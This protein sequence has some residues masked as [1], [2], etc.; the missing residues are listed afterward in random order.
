MK[1]LIILSIGLAVSCSAFCQS[2]F[3]STLQ[4][5]VSLP[6]KS[7]GVNS[8]HMGEGIY[9]GNHLDY[10]AGDGRVKFGLGIYFGYLNTVNTNVEYKKIGQS[11]ADK[12]NL[13]QSQINFNASDFK[14]THLLL[15]PVASFQSHNWNINLWAKG[16]YGLN[17]PGRYA[18]VFKE[19]NLVN[20]IYVNDAGEN[21]NGLAY[22]FGGGIQYFISGNVG[23][24]LG[25]N[26]FGTQTSQ[27]NYN[28]NREKG[29]SPL[30][31]TAKNNFIQASLGINLKFGKETNG[32]QYTNR[33]KSRSN[34]QNN[35]SIAD[36]NDE[37]IIV[38][39]IT[40]SRSNIQNNRSIPEDNNDDDIIVQRIT[41][42][43]S[44]IQN[45]RSIAEDNDED[46]NESTDDDSLVFV[47]E[48]I[49]I[50]TER[51]TPKRDFGDRSVNQ[52]QSVNNYLTG[53]V[54][55][56][57]NGVAI[58]QCGINSMESDPIPGVDV[59]FKRIG[60]A[61]ND[62]MSLST[63]ANKDGSFSFNNIKPGNYI[64]E[65]GD[66]KINIAVKGDNENEYK[67]LDI[68]NSSC[69]NVKENY[70]I[71]IN[72]TLYVEVLPED[73]A[74]TGMATGKKHG[75]NIKWSER[76][77]SSHDAGS[78][79]PTGKRMHKPFKVEGTQFDVDLDNVISNN[80]KNYAEIITAREASTG[81]ATGRLL[82]TVNKKEI[83][84]DEPGV[85]KNIVTPRDPA[86]GL[87]TGKR[88]HKPFKVEDTEFDVDLDNVISSDGKN[89]AEIITAGEAS[90]GMATGR[91]L[92]TVNKKE[93]P[94][95]PASG[96]PTGKRMHKPYKVADTEFDINNEN[97]IKYDG[98]SYA[99]VITAREAGSG[100]ATGRILIT[101]DVDGDG[102]ED[103]AIVS[104]RDP[105]S[106][107]STGKRMHKPFVITKELDADENEIISPRENGSGL[108]TGK[109]MHKPFI[110]T[111]ELD[112]DENEIIS[113]GENGSGLPTGKRMHKPFVITKELDADDSKVQNPLYDHNGNSG[114]NPFHE[115]NAIILSGSNGTN[116]EIFI[117]DN[118]QINPGQHT[119]IVPFEEYEV[120]PIKWMAPESLK[121]SSERKGIQENG[122]KKSKV[123][124]RG[125]DP[126][127]KSKDDTLQNNLKASI[128]TTRSNIKHVSRINCTDG[129][130]RIECI[131]EIE[132][133]EYDAIVTGTFKVLQDSHKGVLNVIR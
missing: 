115:K 21:K 87:P 59:K 102:Y 76:S 61:G 46:I 20:N 91:L 53:F 7:N 126:G 69:D 13:P 81:M 96:L 16:G 56:T 71:S 34:I 95:D 39:R 12:Y 79:L 109:R 23:L 108:P 133:N 128:N 125:W 85:Q 17:E 92:P 19:G 107:L 100:M 104:P 51:Q 54:Y 58:N 114:V 98:K 112:V 131:A 5:G 89:Y 32:Q 113:P 80:G 64:A 24:Q 38:Q 105:Q 33:T 14:S 90:T 25:A 44:N 120:M 70:V 111:K 2:S 49:E 93:T 103:N 45:N 42:S 124:V 86:S 52:M 22:N 101:G 41:K 48:R 6:A 40:K 11:I 55:Q 77:I 123:E 35:R 29:T 75:A 67:I 68:N 62:M 122:I 9:F 118:L 66:D 27:V 26:Y 132:G 106:G 63:K 97:I 36:D 117:P 121:S 72:D 4:T 83:A 1:G 74:G 28:Y 37:G 50:R 31:F 3:Q 88:M 65:V 18:V 82:P 119:N 110:I 84:I 129:S 57:E 30:Y 99:E 73:E 47:P 78:G 10:Y 130:C 94:R 15:G 8:T 116:H 43:R 127:K 60:A